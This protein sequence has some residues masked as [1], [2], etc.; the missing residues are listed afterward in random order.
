MLCFFF[1]VFFFAVIL[2]FFLIIHFISSIQLTVPQVTLSHK[3][4]LL[5]LVFS[6]RYLPTLAHQFSFLLTETMQGSPLR[7]Y[8]M[9]KQQLRDNS[10]P[11]VWDPPEDQT[12]Y[13]QHIRGET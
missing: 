1:V 11:V 10:T 8:P 6:S 9:D 7:I 12:A 13:L 2:C 5:P 3:P 4:S